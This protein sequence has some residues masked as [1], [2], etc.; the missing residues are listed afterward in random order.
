MVAQPCE[1]RLELA[2]SGI[3]CGF[4]V[5]QGAEGEEEYP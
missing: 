1:A 2:L 5:T 4:F 3:V